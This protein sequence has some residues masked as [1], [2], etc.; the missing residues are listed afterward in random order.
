MKPSI[1]RRLDQ[2]DL[3]DIRSESLYI[4]VQRED[5]SHKIE[6]FIHP[7]MFKFILMRS[8]NTYNFAKYYL[9]LELCIKYYNDY[10]H[11]IMKSK[12]EEENKIKL[13]LL[14]NSETLDNFTIHRCDQDTLSVRKNRHGK[15]YIKT[16]H[17]YK[18]YLYVFINGSSRNINK[19]I[20]VSRIKPENL[21]L[22]LRCP[23]HLNF[24]K[25]IKET[26]G[27]SF[28]RQGTEYEDEEHNTKIS[29]TRFF[30]LNDISEDEFVKKINELH[31]SRGLQ[32]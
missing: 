20:R 8:K 31:S 32:K 27:E 19:T 12:L 29:I 23:S 1:K 22:R 24:T 2:Y 7:L 16:I 21:V 30:K 4:S 6:Y 14:N 15:G 17:D 10:F 28:E 5:S 11:M 3:D 13:L 9:L 25:K 26:L 18:E